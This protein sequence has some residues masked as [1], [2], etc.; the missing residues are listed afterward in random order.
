MR[1][2]QHIRGLRRARSLSQRALADR[3]GVTFT[4]ISKI[5]NDKLDFGDYPSEELILRLADALEANE[6]E[7]LIL[8]EKIPARLRQRFMERPDAFLALCELSDEQLDC[9]VEQVFDAGRTKTTTKPR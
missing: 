3:I 7:L 2:G 6:D 5:E 9:L 1:F 8:A 4:Y